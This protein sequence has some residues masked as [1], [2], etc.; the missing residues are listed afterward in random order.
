[1]TTNADKQVADAL[2]S[3]GWS[4]LDRGWPDLLAYNETQNRVM[5]IELKRGT[6]RLRVEQ[7]EMSRVFTNLM[8][9]PFYVARDT[10][11]AAIM[12]KRGRLVLPGHHIN[13][14]RETIEEHKLSMQIMQQRV[15][16]LEQKLDQT[17]TCFEKVATSQEARL[18]GIRAIDSAPGN[19]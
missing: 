17:T 8:G 9:V 12:K 2:R 7:Q 15:N 11:I 13:G 1:M 14:L 18:W 6:D 5:A 4:V 10:D 16:E 3:K 19:G